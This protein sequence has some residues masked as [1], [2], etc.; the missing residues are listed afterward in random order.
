MT[1]TSTMIQGWQSLLIEFEE[2]AANAG[3]SA[4][5]EGQ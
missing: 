5:R 3:A 4:H 2:L 1:S